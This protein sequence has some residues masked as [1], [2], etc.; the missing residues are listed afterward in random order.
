MRVVLGAFALGVT[1]LQ[2]QATLPSR[3]AE[4][5]CCC[6]LVMALTGACLLVRAQGG[7]AYSGADYGDRGA[8]GLHRAR[9]ALACLL[10]AC[11]ATLAGF[12]YAAWRAEL[13]LGDAL[14][15]SWE[16]RDLVVTGHV[17][18]LTTRTV[19]GARFM[20]VVEHAQG[21][22]PPPL[23]A[24]PRHLLLTWRGRAGAHMPELVP[25]ARWRLAVRLRRPHGYAN[26]AGNDAQAV[27]LARGVQA[28]GYVMAHP[29]AMPL[30]R[31]AAG[32]AVAIAR[33]RHALRMRIDAVLGDAP[34]RGIVTA[35]AVGAQD[36][37]SEADMAHLRRTGTSH[38]IAISG[39][40]VGCV[41]AACAALAAAGWRR[42]IGLGRRIARNDTRA[43][44]LVVPAP[45]V[46]SVVGALCALGYALLAGFNVPAQRAF[47]MLA[48]ASAAFVVGREAA[49]SLALAW[50]LALVL[51]VDPWAALAPGFWLSFGAVAA[52]AWAVQ[53]RAERRQPPRR[54][55]RGRMAWIGARAIHV[56]CSNLP[57]AV[58]AQWAVTLGLAPLLACLFSQV[59]IVGPL[60]NAFAIPWVSALVTPLVLAGIGLP[61]PFDA[62]LFS[63]AHALL[64]PLMKLLAALAS[65]DWAVRTLARPSPGAL[66]LACCGVAWSLMPRGWPLRCAAPLTWLPL[67]VPPPGPPV[68]T[69]RLTALDIGQG[70]AIVIET[71]RHTLLFD[72]GP[73]PE[74]T[75]AGERVV[76]PYLR[77]NGVRVLDTLVVSHTD[78]DHAGGAPAVIEAMPLRQLAG[79]L[80]PAH[81][82]WEAARTRGAAAV[83]CVAGQ[84]WQWDG[85]TFAFLWPDA[86][87]LVGKPNAQSCV[88]QVRAPGFTALLAG[89]IE[90][91]AERALVERAAAARQADVLIVAHHGSKTS[92]TERFLDWVEPRIAVFQVG[93]ANRFGHPHPAVLARFEARGSVLARTDRDGA[94]R[95]ALDADSLTLE[96]YRE[97]HR[98]Y[99]AVR[100]E[101]G[102]RQE[103]GAG[104]LAAV[105]P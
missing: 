94:A 19:H 7:G 30:E 40:H 103:G 35:L 29:V 1:L 15:P 60:A 24:A 56:V 80:P 97:T 78:A 86:G 44:P 104:R 38:L 12:V 92:S 58:R 53:A 68:G 28:S 52:I 98:R 23:D 82:L 25:G 8:V 57:D 14:P 71:A 27:L 89:D 87:P 61:A 42:S 33:M 47:W 72:A 10:C 9:A 49:R 105:R 79:S 2:R 69:F 100:P 43:W 6:A 65:P 32:M 4:A 67:V 36:A 21:G 101:Q 48:L 99:W 62:Y 17:S 22:D 81:A 34:H 66:A 3:A 77:A 20:F 70:S 46:A 76:V 88:L 91:G 13:R 11:A 93:Y 55:D 64:A 18:G 31:P 102:G 83:R 54:G 50:A 75:N 63:A 73:G 59:S 51:L 39:L 26:F 5:G 16:G 85:V 84:R 95:I 45:V 37:V 74:S 41:A 90:A 96:R